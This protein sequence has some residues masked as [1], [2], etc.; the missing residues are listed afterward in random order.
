VAVSI[1]VRV[2]LATS[3]KFASPKQARLEGSR[4]EK[5]T[6]FASNKAATFKDGQ[7]GRQYIRRKQENGSQLRQ[8]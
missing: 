1:P 3:S 5:A 7:T 4:M 2:Y 8:T 6:I